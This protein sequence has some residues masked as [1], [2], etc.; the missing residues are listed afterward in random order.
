M[1]SLTPLLGLVCRFI[2]VCESSDELRPYPTGQHS[3]KAESLIQAYFLEQSSQ[4]PW[5]AHLHT[6]MQDYNELL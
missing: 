2:Q 1:F 6:V 4:L 3:D 5:S